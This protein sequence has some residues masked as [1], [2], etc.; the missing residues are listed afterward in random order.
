MLYGVSYIVC[1]FFQWHLN[2]GGHQL[3]L[4]H[5]LPSTVTKLT[6]EAFDEITKVPV[7]S[8]LIRLCSHSEVHTNPILHLHIYSM[9]NFILKTNCPNTP[10]VVQKLPLIQCF[11]ASLYFF[12]LVCLST[13]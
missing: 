3:P 6:E 10:V 11:Q 12:K 9:Y 7:S 1:N 4:K 8:I 13:V 5:L 2:A